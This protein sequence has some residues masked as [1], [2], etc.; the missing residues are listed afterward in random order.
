MS[1]AI[2]EFAEDPIGSTV[3]VV[4]NVATAGLV[5]YENGGL[6]AGVTGQV[7]LDTT[8]DLTG[9]TAAEEANDMARQQFEQQ[10]ADALKVRQD[11][12]LANQRNQT[13]LSN[14]AGSSRN[15]NIGTP[16]KTT[17]TITGDV[18]DFLGV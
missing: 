15:S 13:A 5:G 6:K 2:E 12:I 7:A 4:T 17:K 16:Q 9:A 3:N 14:A 18:S 8:K 11:N 10:T 1:Q